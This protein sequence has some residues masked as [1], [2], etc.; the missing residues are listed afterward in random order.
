MNRMQLSKKSTL[1]QND[2]PTDAKDFY[3]IPRIYLLRQFPVGNSNKQFDA[4]DVDM[5]ITP[6]YLAEGQEV[7]MRIVNGQFQ[8]RVTQQQKES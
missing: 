2:V 6:L 4:V 3:F 8:I 7:T 1:W 5:S